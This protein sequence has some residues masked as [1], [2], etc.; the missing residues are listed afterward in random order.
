MSDYWARRAKERMDGYYDDLEVYQK[1]IEQAVR[2]ATGRIKADVEKILKTFMNRYKLTKEEAMELMNAPVDYESLQRMMKTVEKMPESA[3]KKAIE[4]QIEAKAYGYRISKL[5]A[6][7]I[8]I[9][10]ETHRLADKIV[11]ITGDS[12]R[13]TANKALTTHRADMVKL[14]KESGISAQFGG[15]NPKIVDELVKNSW[16]GKSFSAR[17][18]SN[19]AV[20]EKNLNSVLKEGI[21]TGKGSYRIAEELEEKMNQ[22]LYAAERLVRTETTYIANAAD[23]VGYEETGIKEYEYLAALDERTSEICQKLN[24]FVFKV[25]DAKAGENFPPMHPNCRSTTVAVL[26]KVDFE[27]LRERLEKNREKVYD[28]DDHK[29]L[30]KDS[31]PNRKY[32]SRVSEEDFNRL[33]KNFR[34]RGGIIAQGIEADI[35]LD[36]REA[37]AITL[38]MD[39]IVLKKEPTYSEL[40]EE[41]YHS[42]QYLKEPAGEMPY[43][44]RLMWEID[45]KEHVLKELNKYNVPD[46]E[47]NDYLENLERYKKEIEMVMLNESN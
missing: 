15:V 17:T 23:K 32:Y 22:G 39:T 30:K 24:G 46:I 5:E 12:L 43:K 8:D 44:K 38:G 20:L 4:A 35:Y 18:W 28:E 14:L 9:K 45:A 7:E 3:D 26:P 16:S 6:L 29:I 33:T 11:E 34:E 27:K 41:L 25:E 2:G 19:R 31:N 47:K 10:A 37:D 13:H 40:L 36:A 1:R 21:L 42:E